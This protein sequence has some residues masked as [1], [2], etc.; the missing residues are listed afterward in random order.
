M[1]GGTGFSGR[2]FI[3]VAALIE[4]LHVS[5]KANSIIDFLEH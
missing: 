5:G 1:K 2:L 3:A 4:R